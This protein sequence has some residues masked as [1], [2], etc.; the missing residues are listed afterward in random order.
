MTSRD[1]TPREAF[2]LLDIP[3]FKRLMKSRWYP[4]VIAWPTLAVFAFIT[5]EL[6][7]GP[8]AAHDNFGTAL[9]WVLWWPVLPIMFLFAGRIWCTLCPFGTINDLVQRFVGNNRP[10]PLF[11]KKFGIWI[12]DGIFML[13]TWSDHLWGVVES[14]LNSGILLL[15]ITL[16]AVVSGA[17]FER[18]TW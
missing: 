15:L 13:I 17:F 10:V 2:N 3:A 7:M 4:A 5:Y 1:A 11:L 12:I 14:P 8:S 18:R 9:T 6:V 16:G